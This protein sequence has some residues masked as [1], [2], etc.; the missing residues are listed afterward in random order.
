MPLISGLLWMEYK[1]MYITGL[2]VYLLDNYNLIDFSVLSLYVAS[3]VLRYLIETNHY[4]INHQP[5]LNQPSTKLTN[6]T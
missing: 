1:Q 4:L 2:R 5:L 3:Y 6:Q